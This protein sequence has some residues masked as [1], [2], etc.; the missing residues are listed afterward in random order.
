MCHISFSWAQTRSA[1][2]LLTWREQQEE[3]PTCISSKKCTIFSS[4]ISVATGV[5]YLLSHPASE[6][7]A[8][9]SRHP[10]TKERIS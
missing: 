4:F 10:V 6:A 7:A 3:A 9:E 2:S 1:N 8:M 5:P